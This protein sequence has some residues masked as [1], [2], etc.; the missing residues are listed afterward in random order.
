M[1]LRI[2]PVVG[3][4]L[5]FG[6]RRMETTARIAWLPLLLS[7]I[8]SMAAV[9]AMVSVIAGRVMTFED[10]PTYLGAYQSAMRNASRG[11]A[12][13]P[14]AM[15]TISIA[16]LIAQTMLT[17]SFLAPLIRYAGLGEKPAPGFIRAPFGPDQMR[18]VVS[19]LFSFL[20]VAVL[21]FAPIA[22][23][24]YYTLK[25][26]VA[27]LTQTMAVFPDPN[28][29]HTIELTTTGERIAAEGR[30]WIYDRALPLAGAAPLALAFW[31]LLFFHFNPKNRPK[32]KLPGR[33]VLRAIVTFL[34]AALLLLVAYHY[35]ADFVLTDFRSRAEFFGS[36]SSLVALAKV[37]IAAFDESLEFL[38]KSPEGR[39]IFFGVAAFFVINYISLRLVPYSGVA[40]CR[41][42][43]ALG[44]TLAVSRGWNLLRLF[45]IMIMIGVFIVF[46]QVFVLNLF[47]LQLVLPMVFDILEEATAVATRL[48]N[49]GAVADWVSPTFIWIKNLTNIAIN[50]IWS[51]FSYGVI[52]G[53][54]GR[55]YR[56]S[57]AGH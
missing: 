50:F 1:G 11:F 55:L 52:A 37:D 54:Y 36:V 24:S 21:V 25:Y 13:N 18:F 45:A 38:I 23:T 44:G 47:F 5:H 29:L 51:F 43:L 27:A 15:W 22:A 12:S 40:V 19:G 28:S 32:A 17:A 30:A 20:F 49:S 56:E 3:A 35:L 31:A 53:L 41:K 8:A 2:F 10:I 48:V 33:P 39:L 7:M 9:F 4:A 57:E 6:G 14:G 34:V 46:I 16:S 26:V 42:S